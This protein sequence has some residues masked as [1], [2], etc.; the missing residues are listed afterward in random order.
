MGT[1]AL[2]CGMTDYPPESTGYAGV[3]CSFTWDALDFHNT[4]MLRKEMDQLTTIAKEL[5]ADNR[6]LDAEHILC[7]ESV[8]QI[9]KSVDSEKVNFIQEIQLFKNEAQL[10]KDKM[11]RQFAAEKH[12]LTTEIERLKKNL[13]EHGSNC[14]A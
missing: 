3:M 1:T 5:E 12:A 11:R 7:K 6:R 8:D 14:S 9:R 2:L 4:K 10:E 13:Q